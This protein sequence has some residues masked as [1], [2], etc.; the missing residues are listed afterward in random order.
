MP[1]KKF[2]SSIKISNKLKISN[3]EKCFIVA[4]ISAN[5]AGSL[6]L[7]KKTILKAKEVGVDAVKIQTYEADKITLNVKNKHFLIDD[8]SIWKGKQLYN[9]YKSAET[10]FHGAN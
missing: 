8:K 1:E 7:L 10:P 2:N 9:L 5:H 4:E 3:N 6:D